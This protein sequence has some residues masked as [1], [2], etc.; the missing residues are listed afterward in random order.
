MA[1]GALALFLVERR[2]PLRRQT[3]REGARLARNLSLGAMSMAV[4]A[5]VQTPLVQ[6]LA[7]RA[8]RKRRGLVQRLPLPPWGRDVAAFLQISEQ[9]VANIRFAAVKK[10][11]ESVRGSGLPADIFPELQPTSEEAG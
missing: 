6:P 4:V 10:I 11:H 1:A 5:V 9:Q 7:E 3:R 8:Q 2:W